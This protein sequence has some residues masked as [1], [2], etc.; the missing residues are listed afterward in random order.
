MSRFGLR[1]F[2]AAAFA[3]YGLAWAS[4]IYLAIIGYRGNPAECTSTCLEGAVPGVV[5]W[6]IALACGFRALKLFLA[7]P[8]HVN[9]KRVESLETGSS[10]EDE[11]ILAMANE[12]LSERKRRRRPRS[13]QALAWS[14][15]QVWYAPSFRWQG[16]R[17]ASRLILPL[18][19][20]NKLSLDGWGTF[21]DYYF[22][23]NKPK[24]VLFTL[25]PLAR[26]SLLVV[27]FI[28]ID[29]ILSFTTGQYTSAL[30]GAAFGPLVVILFLISLGP[31]FR[32][33]FL[34]ADAVIG[35][36]LGNRKLLD[37][38]E[39]I[40]QLQLPENESAKRRVGW[41]ARVWPMPNITERIVNL[42]SSLSR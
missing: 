27:P 32:N 17:E 6:I 19:L 15:R 8:A 3:G 21:L 30:F 40:D 10:P 13:V 7:G 14:D 23:Q 37:L 33:L 36:S 38:F 42:Q 16:F 11:R 20:R 34:R 12:L 26:I 9:L 29:A 31:A 28:G 35:E 39:K 2:L 5:G 22:M 25:A 24:R 1:F 18:S 4:G 41:A